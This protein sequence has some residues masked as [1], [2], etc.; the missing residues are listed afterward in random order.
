MLRFKVNSPSNKS[1]VLRLPSRTSWEEAQEQICSGIGMT[2]PISLV[3]RVGKRQVVQAG[4]V[5]SGATLADI[6]IENGNQYDASESM[7]SASRGSSAPSASSSAGASSVG[8][9]SLVPPAPAGGI[10]RVVVPADNSC[11]FTAIGYL[12]LG[13]TKAMGGEVRDLCVRMVRSSSLPDGALEGKSPEEYAAWLADTSHWGGAIEVGLLAQHF[14]VQLAVVEVK[15]TKVYRF[16]DGAGKRVAYLINDG[17]HYDPLARPVDGVSEGGWTTTF[18]PD[19]EAALAGVL[20]LAAEMKR[21]NEFVDT[22]SFAL[23]CLV[24]G[25]GLKGQKEALE[26]AKATSHTNFAQNNE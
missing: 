6:G 10:Q 11:L 12:L 2:G 8:A 20:A 21:K 22:A 13:G 5:A 26:H 9:P 3:T 25:K 7:P 16:G 14:G 15:S 4:E 24:C 19:D 23:K 17:I 1:L 18:A